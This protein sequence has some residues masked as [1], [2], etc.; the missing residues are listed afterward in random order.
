LETKSPP[1][2]TAGLAGRSPFRRRGP[3]VQ[4]HFLHRALGGASTKLQSRIVQG[5]QPAG[6]TL[7]HLL[8]AA[9]PLL[10][11]EQAEWIAALR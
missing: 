7:V 6:L 9:L 1:F 11:S 2:T 3:R 4:P 10:W 8:R 5:R